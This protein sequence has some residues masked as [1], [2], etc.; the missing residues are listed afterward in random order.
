MTGNN[1]QRKQPDMNISISYKSKNKLEYDSPRS[2]SSF[3]RFAKYNSPKA[4][5]S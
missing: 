5:I 3:Y 4:L 2:I 1:E